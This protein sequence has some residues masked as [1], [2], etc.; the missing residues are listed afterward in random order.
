MKFFKFLNLFIPILYLGILASCSDDDETTSD[1]TPTAYLFERE[2]DG[3]MVS[4]VSYGGQ[5]TRLKQADELYAAL[6]SENPDG[7]PRTFTEQELDLMF[8]GD[9]NGSSGFYNTELNGTS[10][11]IRS[12]TSAYANTASNL[13]VFDGWLAE[14]ANDVAPNLDGTASDGFAGMLDGY[15]LNAAGQELDQLFFKS[16]IGAFALDQIINNYITPSQLD[17]GTRRD[18]NTAGILEDG[19]PYTTMEHKWDEGFGYLYGQVADVTLNYGLPAD[20][21]A[22]GN[23]LM[24]YF[25]KVEDNYEPGIAETVYNAFIAGRHAITIADYDARD[26]AAATIKMELSKVIGY[27]AKHYLNDYMT[28]AGSGNISGA[29]HSLSEGYGFIFSLQFTNDG[30]D[31]PYMDRGTIMYALTGE[32]APPGMG[33]YFADFHNLNSVYITD[34][35]QGMIA[36]IDNAFGW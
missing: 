30:G 14:F 15:Q 32:G 9:N 21:E 1:S 26:A 4:T 5:T 20:G 13:A 2:V 16:L 12:K 29:H 35:Q 34:P 3:A 36:L 33:A 18:D 27:Y 25:K 17:S 10:K 6:N 28:K 11:I 31:S 7:S 19:D 8:G 22:T 24:K 23:L